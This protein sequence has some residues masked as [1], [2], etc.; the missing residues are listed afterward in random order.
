[1]D[2]A[3]GFTIVELLIVIVVIGIL[4]AISIVTY[5]NMQAKTR[6]SIRLQD[7]ATI[8][9]ALEMHKI[10][11]GG[12]PSASA[13]PGIN[14]WEV[15]VDSGFLQSLSA[16]LQSIPVDPTNSTSYH[17]AYY[18]D[19]AGSYGCPASAG[20]FYVLRITGLESVDGRQVSDLGPCASSITLSSSRRPSQ[21]Q[22]VFMGFENR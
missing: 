6:D 16:Q 15:S 20:A 9:K 3:R 4:A 7:I 21:T 13:N 5:S 17:Y 2:R 10:E 12:Y 22:A 18:R 19:A 8:R 14:A 11:R 1:M